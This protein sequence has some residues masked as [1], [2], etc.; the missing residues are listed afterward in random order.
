[1]PFRDDLTQARLQIERLEH[2]KAELI[3]HIRGERKPRSR[4]GFSLL[5]VATTMAVLVGVTLCGMLG[6]PCSVA[7]KEPPPAEA[8]SAAPSAVPVPHG[9]D[10]PSMWP[11]FTDLREGTGQTVRSGDKLVVHYVGTLTSG[12]QFDSSRERNEPFR[13][14]IGEGHVIKG[15]EQGLLGMKVG[16]L[17]RLTIPPD[18]AYGAKGAPPT[19]PPNAT[20]VFDVE[21]LAIEP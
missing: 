1:M 12:T 10:P 17:R 9:S 5:V 16:G 3:A 2:D 13:F 7:V 4:V 18:L 15:W 6:L 21:L 20:L 11:L 8:R 14:K 19:I